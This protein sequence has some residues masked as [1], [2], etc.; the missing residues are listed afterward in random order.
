VFANGQQ[1]TQSWN[2]TLTSSGATVTA[3]NASH[4]GNLAVGAATSFGFLATW[5]NVTNAVPTVRCTVS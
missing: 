4:N 3:R 1:I 2:T 5:N